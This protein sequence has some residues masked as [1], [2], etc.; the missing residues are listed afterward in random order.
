[1]NHQRNNILY[2]INLSI[3]NIRR[4]LEYNTTEY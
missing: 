3:K 1:M 2:I 4:D